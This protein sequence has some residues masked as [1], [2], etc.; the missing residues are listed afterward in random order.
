MDGAEF[1]VVEKGVVEAGEV[2]L[3]DGVVG[4]RHGGSHL[5]GLFQKVCFN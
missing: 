4:R 3:G 5:L 2:E 1:G